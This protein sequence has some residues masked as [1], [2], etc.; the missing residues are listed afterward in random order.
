ML[1]RGLLIGLGL[2]LTVIVGG[3]LYVARSEALNFLYD[4]INAERA[5]LEDFPEDFNLDYTEINLTAADG[6]N[7]VGWYMP[8]QN[9][10]VIILQHG[11]KSER[12]EMVDEAAMLIR[13]GYGTAMIDVRGHGQSDGELISFGRYEM[14]DL[15]VLYE[16]VIAQPGVDADK[17]GA[18]GN[19]MGGSLLI[20]YAA[21]NP[22]I[23]ALVADSAFSSITDTVQTS[24]EHFTGLPGWLF[25][26]PM[27]WF[28]E[29]EVGFS[30]EEVAATGKI[31]QLSP[32]P[33][34]LLQGGSDVVVDPDSGRK[35]YEAA[36]EPVE[37][38]YEESLD[39]VEFF[40]AY[41]AEYEERIV[42][43]FDEHV[44]GN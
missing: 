43:F 22:N 37:L 9:G 23:K 4:P 28:A 15:D 3:F 30:V 35:L 40:S 39:H 8:P 2:L 16:F 7:L 10:S 1:K 34:F 41:P 38:W 12:D 26:G 18:L 20:Q 14:Q 17:I 33:I 31:G 29:R 36:N 11:Y 27:I 5:T 42:G 25:G 21:Q 44:L 32:R 13:N 24:V 19:S 6:T